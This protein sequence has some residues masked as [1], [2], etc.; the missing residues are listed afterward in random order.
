MRQPLRLKNLPQRK[1]QRKLLQKLP[2]KK[3]P[4]LLHHQL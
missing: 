4:K 2:K 3:F 1:L